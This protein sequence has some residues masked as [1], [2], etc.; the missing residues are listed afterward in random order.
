MPKR[1]FGQRLLIAV[2]VLLALALVAHLGGGRL[3]HAL[4]R[5]HGRH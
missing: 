2:V 1:S 5:L 4:G 3:I